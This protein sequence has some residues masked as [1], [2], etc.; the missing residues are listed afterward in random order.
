[1]PRLRSCLGR[2]LRQQHTGGGNILIE[3]PVFRRIH[4]VHTAAQ[5]AAGEA[6]GTQRAPHGSRVNALGH[7]GDHH[8]ALLGQLIAQLLG[9]MDPVRRTVT[10]THHGNRHLLV[11]KG[12]GALAVQ[13]QGRLVDVPQPLRVQGICHGDEKDPLSGAVGQNA[14]RRCHGLVIQQSRLLLSQ[15]LYLPQSFLIRVVYVLR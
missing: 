12:H 15:S 9:A 6:S 7:T 14:I 4:H 8:A 10:G 5:Y 2:V 3:P 1:M 13:Q 11:K